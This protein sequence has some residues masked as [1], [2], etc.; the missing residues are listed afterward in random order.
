ME[1]EILSPEE[2]KI[3]E[4]DGILLR[5][6]NGRR[7]ISK[8]YL[9]S[10][11]VPSASPSNDEF[12]GHNEISRT[13]T[14]Q[15]HRTRASQ[16]IDFSEQVRSLAALKFIGLNHETA[17]DIWNRW[18]S[19]PDPMDN[20][21]DL[22]DY[23]YSHT[24]NLWRAAWSVYT[25]EDALEK[26]G[27]AKWLQKAILDPRSRD[28]Y[29]TG[30]LK[31]WLDD[32]LRTNF[33]SLVRIHK[34]LKAYPTLR[35][36]GK[37]Q[38]RSSLGNM[39]SENRHLPKPHVCVTTAPPS[40]LPGHEVFYKAMHPDEIESGEDPFISQD[41]AINMRAI[42][43]Y[44]GGDFNPT[45]PAW[46]WTPE[47][48]TALA[49]KTYAEIR[50]PFGEVWIICIQVPTAFISTLRKKELWYSHDWKAYVWHCHKQHD[51][52]SIPERY[53]PYFV[54]GQTQTD[55]II[56]HICKKDGTVIT[57]IPADKVQS[58]MSQDN[59]LLIGDQKATQWVI[60]HRDVANRLGREIRGKVHV[61]VYKAKEDEK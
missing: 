40:I 32:S 59:I 11:L 9:S 18:S 16:D 8:S 25:D 43:A 58:T 46:Y 10:S 28:I 31:R 38:K 15:Y 26:L 50:K 22:M 17:K 42:R 55:L 45:N 13:A 23:V 7:K 36:N 3:L 33:N 57:K 34:Q 56:G 39:D 14:V 53:H 37:E 6:H 54:P 27:V 21:D 47:H 19:R 52:D 24:C 60:M 2:C 48:E 1:D 30:T 51:E 12:P 29:L 4:D 35:G 5:S 49:Y 20:P 44:L 41:G 61:D